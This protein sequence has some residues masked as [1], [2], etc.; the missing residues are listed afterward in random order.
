M[1]EFLAVPRE[2]I[3][4][5]RPGVEPDTYRP[6]GPRVRAPFRIGFLSRVS[7]AKGLDILVEA[8]ILLSKNR[9]GKDAVLSVA[10]DAAGS[11][12]GFL[13]RLRERIASAGLT[14]R[15]EYLGEIGLEEKVRF[16]RSLSVFCLPSRYAEQRAMACLEAMAAGVP[17]IVPKLGLFPELIGLTGGGLLAPFDRAQGALSGVERAPVGDAAAFADALGSLMDDPDRADRMGRAAS[18]GVAR[19][20]SAEGMTVQTLAIYEEAL[21]ARAKSGS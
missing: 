21:R 12:S 2:R 7:P 14:E 17:A 9:P 20:F 19:H 16:L 8:F 11:N 13:D 4:V 6:S 1:S 18:E 10:G 3:Q 15:F 5:V